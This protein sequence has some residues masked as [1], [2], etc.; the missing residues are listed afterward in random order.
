MRSTD[1]SKSKIKKIFYL[2]IFSLLIIFI[3]YLLLSLKINKFVFSGE[4]SYI[5]T[6]LV[7]I[8]AL[9]RLKDQSLLFYNKSG[10]E[11]EL[12]NN[13]PQIENVSYEIKSQDTL[14]ISF[15]SKNYC[16][17]VV[18]SDLNKYL[19]DTSG[20]V[21]QKLTTLKNYE[22]EIILDQKIDTDTSLN[23]KNVLKMNEIKKNFNEEGYK[24][25]TFNLDKNNISIKVDNDN[26]IIID[27]NSEVKNLAN[28]YKNL[29]SYLTQNQK[30]YSIVDFR[31]DKVVVK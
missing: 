4:T 13:Y 21:F 17:V 25:K 30:N 23:P 12:R 29:L 1:N 18:D 7:K 15:K 20:K 28:K 11:D 2:F 14:E 24:I 8:L 6:D 3:I 9:N 31:F 10:F 5:D 16:C 22:N 26:L 27:D 19:I